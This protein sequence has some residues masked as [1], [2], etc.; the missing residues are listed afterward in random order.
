M[1]P[2]WRSIKIEELRVLESLWDAKQP[3]ACLPK[4]EKW[5]ASYGGTLDLKLA[6][7]PLELADSLHKRL[8]RGYSSPDSEALMRLS[9]ILRGI[10][11]GFE[12]GGC[13]RRWTET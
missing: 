6:P 9:A 5:A 3:E 1:H 7:V 13:W 11:D 4:A 10:F 8:V 12:P 2:V